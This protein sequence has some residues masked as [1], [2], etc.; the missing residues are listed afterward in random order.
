MQRSGCMNRE[1]DCTTWCCTGFTREGT[2]HSRQPPTN[3]VADYACGLPQIHCIV[4]TLF[5]GVLGTK[6]EESTSARGERSEDHVGG[7]GWKEKEADVEKRGGDGGA[8]LDEGED[9]EEAR[10][11]GDQGSGMNPGTHWNGLLEGA[12]PKMQHVAARTVHSALDDLLNAAGH[13]V[14]GRNT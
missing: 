5:S 6:K 2:L 13:L 10:D 9:Q 12:P 4:G 1:V 7:L 11:P 14:F 3:Q 8:N